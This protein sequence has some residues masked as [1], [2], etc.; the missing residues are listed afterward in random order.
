MSDNAATTSGT[1]RRLDHVDAMRP[2][3]QFAV[4]GTHAILIF[5][6]H[7]WPFEWKAGLVFTHF[8]R[9]A[10][11][12]VSACMLAYSYRNA[13]RVEI[14]PYAWRRFVSVG[15]PYLVWTAIYW[16]WTSLQWSGSFPYYSV[17]SGSL[18]LDRLLHLGT[19]GYYHLYYLLVLAQ[20]YVV[21]P[22]LLRFIRRHPKSHLP[23]LIGSLVFGVLLSSAKRGAWFGF[24]FD[25]QLQNRL[26]ISYVFWLVAGVIVAL[27]FDAFHDWVVARAK[28]I[29]AFTLVT[30]GLAIATNLWHPVTFATTYFAAGKDPFAP[31]A[32]PYDIGAVLVVYLLGVFLV[33]PRRGDLTRRVVASGSDN[34]YGIYLSQMV[35]IPVVR[36]VMRHFDFTYHLS[37]GVRCVMAVLGAYLLGYL[38]TGLVARTPLAKSVVGRSR[39]TW[40]SLIPRS[41]PEAAHGH[42]GQG[43]LDET[44]R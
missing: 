33:S 1:R 14:R 6:P 16:F 30:Y 40:R 39:A 32:L 24:H 44:K 31:V 23:L 42:A 8:S 35:F 11:L 36:R 19:W 38:F 12:F 27:N 21:F 25:P 3:K 43:P 2:V 29:V 9:N 41:T 37:S 28:A 10:F 13:S 22:W 34:A 26:I 17:R 18:N 4:I 20:F 7:S 5:H 15:V